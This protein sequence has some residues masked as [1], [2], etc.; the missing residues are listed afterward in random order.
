MKNVVFWLL[1]ILAGVWVWELILTRFITFVFHFTGWDEDY[2]C[3][4]CIFKK[5]WECLLE[6]KEALVILF[7]I[8]VLLLVNLKES[9]TA[10]EEGEI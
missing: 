7:G 6:V 3:Q 9:A 4:P 8:L 10:E 5:L 2:D 1:V